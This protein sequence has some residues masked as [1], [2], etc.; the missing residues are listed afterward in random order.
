[1]VPRPAAA[2]SLGSSV[3]EEE[4]P[5]FAHGNG[6]RERYLPQM[7]HLWGRKIDLGGK[8]SLLVLVDLLLR[9]LSF[10]RD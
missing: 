8:K 6:G 3:V 5:K 4:N 10:P 9:N 1:M 2:A 7:G